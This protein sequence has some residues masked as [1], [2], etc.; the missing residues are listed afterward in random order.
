MVATAT[1]IATK[2]IEVTAEGDPIQRHAK[3]S[4]DAPVGFEAIRVHFEIDAL[5]QR[6]SN[7]VRY[8]KCWAEQYWRELW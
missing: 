6:R 8:T 4:K 2:R 5:R 1:G 7:C 3:I